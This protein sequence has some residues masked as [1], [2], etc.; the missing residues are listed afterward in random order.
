RRGLDLQCPAAARRGCTRADVVRVRL[1]YR[2]VAPGRG[3]ALP[4]PRIAGPG[5]ARRERGDW[6]RGAGGICAGAARCPPIL[7][8]R[9]AVPSVA[10]F[11]S[12]PRRLRLR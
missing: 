2:N 5:L 10:Y 7:A 3:R 9:V 11:V 4:A 12:L 1:R 6:I 8:C